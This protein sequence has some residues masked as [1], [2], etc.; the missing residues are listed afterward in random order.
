MTMFSS[1]K[2]DYDFRG[3]SAVFLTQSGFMMSAM[4]YMN[5]Y[6]NKFNLIYFMNKFVAKKGEKPDPERT[7]DLLAEIEQQK[8]DD[9]WMPC[10]DDITDMI[11][12]GKI[13]HKK[14][15]NAFGRGF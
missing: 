12:I 2:D 7:N 5:L 11:T 8:A 3:M 13:S 10:M 9:D 4:I 14:M 15:L 1:I 6:E